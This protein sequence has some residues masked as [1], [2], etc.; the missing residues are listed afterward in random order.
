M[1]LSTHKIFSTSHR[2]QMLWIYAI[3]NTTEMIDLET[4]WNWSD[5]E[6]IGNAMCELGLIINGELTIAIQTES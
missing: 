3:S 6:F 5:E 4:I 1:G 2:F